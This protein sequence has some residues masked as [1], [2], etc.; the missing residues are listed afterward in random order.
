MQKL[1][2]LWQ[3]FAVFFKIGLF[4]VGGGLTMLPI[5]E[6]EVVIN[7]K[8]IEPQELNDMIVLVQSTPGAIAVNCAIFTG[9]RVAGIFGGIAAMLGM[10]VPSFAVITIIS[11]FLQYVKDNV[12]IAAAFRGIRACVAVLITSAVI[13]L[14]KP[15][16]KTVFAF[17]VAILVFGIT[18]WLKIDVIYIILFGAIMGIAVQT[19]KYNKNQKADTTQEKADADENNKNH[20]SSNSLDIKA[21]QPDNNKNKLEQSCDSRNDGKTEQSDKNKG[22]TNQEDFDGKGGEV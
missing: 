5:I 1:K 15:M 10:I 16:E 22:N 21:E 11:F 17:A 4:T 3:L 6:R 18:L 12:Y 13:K 9:F 2:N 20:E 7:K 19:I 14:L 8:W